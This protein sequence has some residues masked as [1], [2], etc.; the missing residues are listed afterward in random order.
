MIKFSFAKMQK[1][2]LA[3]IVVTNFKLLYIRNKPDAANFAPLICR[4]QNHG[5]PYLKRAMQQAQGSA[6]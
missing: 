1:P 4:V 2:D 6:R 5:G 3:V